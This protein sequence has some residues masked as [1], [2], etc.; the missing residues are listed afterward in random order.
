MK[1]IIAAALLAMLAG[2][3]AAQDIYRPA[4]GPLGS[5]LGTDGLS[6]HATQPAFTVGTPVVTGATIA[7]FV[8]AIRVMCSASCFVALSATN[9]TSGESATWTVNAA[10]GLVLPA[11]VPE[12]FLTNGGEYV[13]VVGVSASGTVYLRTMTR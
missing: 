1:K 2:S 11:N 7:Q 5:L 3:A 4:Y 13:V 9:F 8:D 12:Y 10:S 6:F